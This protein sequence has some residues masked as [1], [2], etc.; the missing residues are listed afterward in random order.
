MRERSGLKVQLLDQVSGGGI[1]ARI[2]GVARNAAIDHPL[3]PPFF[4]P[5]QVADVQHV[6][7]RVSLDLAKHPLSIDEFGDGDQIR[8][9][10]HALARRLEH[11]LNQSVACT[12]GLVSGY[13]IA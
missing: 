9:H 1:S 3:T 11:F 4:Q 6:A 10:V 8:L 13:L 2:V 7:W 12:C 5:A